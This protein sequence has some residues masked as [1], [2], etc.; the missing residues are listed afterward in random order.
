MNKVVELLD[1]CYQ[2][3]TVVINLIALNWETV[4]GHMASPLMYLEYNHD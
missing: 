3:F 4:T 2:S 1:W